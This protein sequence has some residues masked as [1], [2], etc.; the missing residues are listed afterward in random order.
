MRL[1]KREVTLNEKDTLLDML[2]F[3]QGLA[4]SYRRAAK[5][6]DRKEERETLLARADDSADKIRRLRSY[7]E[8]PPKM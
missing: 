5:E 1:E 2:F 6:T 8:L 3:E 7:L 4:K